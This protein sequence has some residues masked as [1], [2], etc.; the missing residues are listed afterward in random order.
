MR[1]FR[2]ITIDGSATVQLAVKNALGDS[3]R[4]YLCL[5][6]ITRAWSQKIETYV[7]GQNQEESKDLRANTRQDLHAIMYEH[8]PHKVQ[9]LVKKFHDDWT[10]RFPSFAEYIESDY[11]I[12]Q[13]RMRTWTKDYRQ[14]EVYAEMNTK[15][16]VESWHNH[17]KSKFVK[18][19]FTTRADRMIYLLNDIVVNYFKHEN[20]QAHV[21]IRR[22]SKGEIL[23]IL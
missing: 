23:D 4:I 12:S 17:L 2:F 18:R 13:D 16:L 1:P 15:T 9:E 5:W 11:S 8:D 20:S 19:Q 6:H 3:V 10:E 21:R 14:D 22:K 7:C